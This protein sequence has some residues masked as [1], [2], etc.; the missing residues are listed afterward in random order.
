MSE[1]DIEYVDGLYIKPPVTK[2]GRPLPEFIKGKGSIKVADM[3]GWLNTIETEWVNFDLKES[4]K[5]N[6]YCAVDDWTPTKDEEYRKGAA[7][8]KQ[9]L[10]NGTEVEDDDI[11]FN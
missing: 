1:K 10:A 9:A 5:G 3:I 11:P 8:A 6:W 7:Q 4:K 2:D